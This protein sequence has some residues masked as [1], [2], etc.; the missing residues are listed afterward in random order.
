MSDSEIDEAVANLEVKL[1]IRNGFFD[2]LLKED[3]WSFIIKSHA[4][5]EAA[6]SSLL[7][8][9]VGI[10]TLIEV[11]ARIELSNKSYGKVIF[12]KHLNLLE[13]EERRFLASLSEIRNKLVHNI[14]EMEFSLTEY[15]G[16][17]N[18]EQKQNFIKS[19]GYCYLTE[20]KQGDKIVENHEQIISNPKRSIW[21]SLKYIL[22]IISIQ[23]DLVEADQKTKK[24]QDEIYR[25]EKSLKESTSKT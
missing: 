8:K 13:K 21:L 9:Y 7:T 20:N 12:L 6:A 5:V 11:F 25:M 2:E 16:G 14:K 3:D 24:L 1:N 22:A 23:I 19:F 15:V 17:L 18:I 10:E 4:I